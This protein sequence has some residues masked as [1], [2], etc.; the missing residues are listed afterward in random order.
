MDALAGEGGHARHQSAGRIGWQIVLW[1]GVA[2]IIV[3]G[4]SESLL[5]VALYILRVVAEMSRV[6]P[7]IGDACKP[8]K[9]LT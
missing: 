1:I 5:T 6:P 7:T 3:N 8:S 2:G 9:L 4:C